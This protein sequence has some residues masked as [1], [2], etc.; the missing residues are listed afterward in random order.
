MLLDLLF[1]TRATKL[2]VAHDAS[3]P[4]FLYLALQDVHEPIEVPSA[5]SAPFASAIHDGVRRTYAGMVSVVDECV[6][7]LTAS[8][9]RKAMWNN[10]ILVLERQRR[11]GRIWRSEHTLP[12]HKTTLWE[13]G[14]RGQG[15]RRTRSPASRSKLSKPLPCHRLA[16]NPRQRSGWGPLAARAQVHLN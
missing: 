1:T 2:I 13:G 7:N 4:F 9:R 12:R 8:L 11:L 3:Q 16:A 6:A 15:R 5:Y 10:S 14:I